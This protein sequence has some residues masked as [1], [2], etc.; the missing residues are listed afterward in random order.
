MARCTSCCVCCMSQTHTRAE[1]HV[2]AHPKST[3][4][5]I[6]SSYHITSDAQNGSALSAIKIRCCEFYDTSRIP[7]KYTA[8]DRTTVKAILRTDTCLRQSTQL[9]SNSTRF[10]ASNF[11]L[12]T[13]FTITWSRNLFLIAADR[14]GNQ[15]SNQTV[16]AALLGCRG[17][18]RRGEAR[19]GQSSLKTPTYFGS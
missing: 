1:T 2:R 4:V 8:L 11:A 19:N 6:F 12:T 17:R 14:L 7:L 16:A 18:G 3:S 10:R 9:C 15:A 5:H 13:H